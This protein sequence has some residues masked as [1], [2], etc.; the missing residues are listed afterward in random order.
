[1]N[2]DSTSS[3]FANYMIDKFH[4]RKKPNDVANMMKEDLEKITNQLTI[5]NI[6]SGLLG[7]AVNKQLKRWNTGLEFQGNQLNYKQDDDTYF[8][9]Y[10]PD[11]IRIGANFNLDF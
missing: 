8:L 7:F 10:S 3:K 1:M 5:K 2:P 11:E 6:S 4:H 9:K